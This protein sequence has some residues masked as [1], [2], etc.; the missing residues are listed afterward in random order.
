MECLVVEADRQKR[1]EP[2]QECTTIPLD[3]TAGVDSPDRHSGLRRRHVGP[4]IG[5]RPIPLLHLHDE[6]DVVICGAERAARAVIFERPA[7]HGSA[8]GE[9]RGGN[10]VAVEGVNPR[11]LECELEGA[12]SI[13]PF[14]RDGRQPA[15]SGD[16]GAYS[17]VR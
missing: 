10:S 13:D 8:G 2:V 3:A 7:E 9:Q 16:S 17:N 1:R 14:P 12:G 5:R 11:A 4:D 6:V 15:H